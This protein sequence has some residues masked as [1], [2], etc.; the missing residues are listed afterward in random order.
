MALLSH[1]RP[2]PKGSAILAN[3]RLGVRILLLVL[4]VIPCLAFHG[5]WGLFRIPSPWPRFFLGLTARVIG[6]VVTTTGAR[7]KRDVFYVAN[8]VGWV[9]IP[10][11]AGATGCAFVAQDLIAGWPV[12]G[13]LA[14]RNYTVFVSRTDRLGIGGQ[15]ETLR[16]AIAERTPV[17]I[18]PEGTTT[19]GRSLLPFKPGLFAVMMP[20]PKPMMVQPVVLHFDA[21]G[22]ALAW[23]CDET[24]AQNALRVFRNGQVMRVCVEF[25]PPFDPGAQ[26]DRKA[27]A[28]QART[29][30]AGALAARTG[31][32]LEPYE[33]FL[34]PYGSAAPDA[35]EDA[36]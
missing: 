33:R 6:V 5:L 13:W 23:V 20:P 2:E 17:A 1:P 28:T 12:I 18:F 26:P 14:R 35:V 15:I 19:N 8:H 7:L 4:L 27:I 25:L 21:V 22:V 24:A 32:P 9:D 30:I 11:L 34:P 36:G 3:V 29:A 10:I 31:Y 16:A